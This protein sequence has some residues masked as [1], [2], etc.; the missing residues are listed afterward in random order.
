M[1]IVYRLLICI[2]VSVPISALFTGFQQTGSFSYLFSFS[3]AIAFL[4]TSVLCVGLAGLVGAGDHKDLQREQG[5]VKWFNF[6]KGF[7]FI[8][9]ENGDDIFVH[10]RS[11]RGRSRRLSEGQRVEFV[12][13]EGEKGLQADDVT[14]IDKE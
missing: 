2:V 4:A 14:L 11:I 6:S 1:T 12:V 8:T 5:K 13:V 3:T 7:G 10:Y 9:R